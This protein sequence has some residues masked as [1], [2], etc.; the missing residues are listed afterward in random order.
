MDFTCHFHL[1][2]VYDILVL[3]RTRSRES[4]RALAVDSPRWEASKGGS[5]AGVDVF[6]SVSVGLDPVNICTGYAIRSLS[7]RDCHLDATAR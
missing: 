6:P 7:I 5:Y 2:R 1:S 4:S 3:L